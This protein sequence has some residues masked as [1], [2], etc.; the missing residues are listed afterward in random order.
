MKSLLHCGAQ[1]KAQVMW[2]GLDGLR[3]PPRTA[4]VD[5][6]GQIA[7]PSPSSHFSPELPLEE[8]GE[9][10]EYNE[11]SEARDA[12]RSVEVR[13]DLENAKSKMPFGPC[14][15]APARPSLSLPLGGGEKKYPSISSCSDWF[16][17]GA[18]QSP[19]GKPSHP[20][21]FLLNETRNPSREVQVWKPQGG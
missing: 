13:K 18:K 8:F 7:A 4:K 9:F 21:R 20:G 17:S 6:T 11:L 12:P 19:G 5:Q 15:P 14:S 2:S 16:C 3:V 1:I 10:G